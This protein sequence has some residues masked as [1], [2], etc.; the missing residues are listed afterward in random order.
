MYKKLYL[1]LYVIFSMCSLLFSQDAFK[2]GEDLFM[3]NNAAE[4]VS[5]LE[6]ALSENQ[7]NVQAALYLGMAYQQ[8]QR[9]DEAIAV[10][11]KILPKAAD[12]TALIAYNLGN[13]YFT[14]G[15]AAFAEQYYTQALEADPFYSSALLNRANARIR[16][17]AM[18]DALKDYEQFLVQ[19]P[20]SP[21]R[22]QIEQMMAL[23]RGEAAAEQRR[24]EMEQLAAEEEALRRQ[25]L[26]D[27]VSASLQAASEE[28][29]GIQAGS[30]EVL[31]YE[32]EFEL[33]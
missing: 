5:F 33:E 26:L 18:E 15:S 13:I 11:R 32:G 6:A 29:R 2:R 17:G 1:S 19:V 7:S 14:R 25:Q 24:Q 30:E 28:T 16:T 22:P 20:T 10:F 27:E 21:K 12:K 8:L 4:A 3:N 31:D 23:I 9:P